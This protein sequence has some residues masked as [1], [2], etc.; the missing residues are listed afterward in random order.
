[1]NRK[2]Y[3]I[4]EMKKAAVEMYH[5]VEDHY[6]LMSANDR[7]RYFIPPLS[8]ELGI[9]QGR[10]DEM[11]LPWLRWW[12]TEGNLLLTGE[13]RAESERQRAE[14]VQQKSDRLAER[15]RQMGINPDD[16]P[17]L[18]GFSTGM[19][20]KELKP[21]GNLSDRFLDWVVGFHAATQLTGKRSH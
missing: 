4:Y 14:Q 11:D 21:T 1:M 5:L 20:L 18:N 12:N 7:N 6:Q 8:V 2:F 17:L 9:W 16:L 10:Y 13:E 15:L 19:A 3:G